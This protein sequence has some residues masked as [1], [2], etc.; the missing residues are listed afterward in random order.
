MKAKNAQQDS[1][2]DLKLLQDLLDEK[3]PLGDG[4]GRRKHTTVRE[5]ILRQ[6]VRKA[7]EGNV[8]AAKMI[9]KQRKAFAETFDYW[10]RAKKRL[11]GKSLASFA[12]GGVLVIPAGYNIGKVV[13]HLFRLPTD[14]EQHDFMALLWQEEPAA[15]ANMIE[16]RTQGAREGPLAGP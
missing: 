1:A 8:R 6:Q 3:L 14:E 5:Q 15:R 10:S 11:R 2:A 12:R 7:A 16:R 4:S 9:D 13:S